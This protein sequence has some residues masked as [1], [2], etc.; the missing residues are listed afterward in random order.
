MK[1]ILSGFVILILSVILLTTEGCK[2]NSNPYGTTTTPLPSGSPL[3]NTIFI[4]S[5]AFS[6]STDTITHGTTITWTNND[7]T[8]HTATSNTGAWD[9]GSISSGGSKTA[10]FNTV[11]TYP[12]HCAIHPSMMGTI[13]VK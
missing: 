12:Y 9:T 2:D 4:K 1:K 7:A 8:P 6:P 13:V 11:G 10:T 5:F 3:P